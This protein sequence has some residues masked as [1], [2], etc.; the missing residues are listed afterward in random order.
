MERQQRLTQMLSRT[1]ERL[2]RTVPVTNQ[3]SV[4]TRVAL[5]AQSPARGLKG[6]GSLR[7]LSYAAVS[8]A[9]P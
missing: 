8:V 4:R 5:A 6:V 9:E 1:A 7:G 3:F 2:V